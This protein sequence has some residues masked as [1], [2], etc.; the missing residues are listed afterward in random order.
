MHGLDFLF[1]FIYSI[2][3]SAHPRFL[4]LYGKCLCHVYLYLEKLG[5]RTWSHSFN[6]N[7]KQ[8]PQLFFHLTISLS[9]SAFFPIYFEL[10]CF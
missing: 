5:V 8:V 10:K 6:T 3:T 1:K 9:L 7:T 2:Y 4:T